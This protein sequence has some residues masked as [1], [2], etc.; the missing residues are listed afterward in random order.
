MYHC[1]RQLRVNC[2]RAFSAEFVTSPRSHPFTLCTNKREYQIERNAFNKEQKEVIFVIQQQAT[3]EGGMRF[4]FFKVSVCIIP[5]R[6][7][8]AACNDFNVYW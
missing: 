8:V 7:P 4:K 3:R 2:L 5:I 1:R 6:I